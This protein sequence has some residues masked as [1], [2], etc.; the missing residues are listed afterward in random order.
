MRWPFTHKP[1]PKPAPTT[2][3]F[4]FLYDTA[5]PAGQHE[6]F[7]RNPDAT[8]SRQLTNDPTTDSWWPRI[9]PDKQTI[10]YCSTPKGVRDTDFTKV[11][12]RTVHIDGTDDRQVLGTA[13]ETNPDW[14]SYGHPDWKPDGTT[15]VMF[16]ITQ[17]ASSLL[18]EYDTTSWKPSRCAR[19]ENAGSFC[20][21]PSYSPDGLKIVFV[22]NVAGVQKLSTVGTAGPVNSGYT[23][24]NN[25]PASW[26][27]NDPYYSPDSLRIGALLQTAAADTEHSGGQ[28][29]I[30]GMSA[31]GKNLITIIDDGNINSKPDWIDNQ[32]ILFHRLVYS[33]G[34]GGFGVWTI[35]SDGTGLT[36][37]GVTGEYPNK[38]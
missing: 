2:S 13:V 23:E 38:I 6:I 35:R 20:A 14:K 3:N 17:T 1:A 19:L 34:S 12:I 30:I 11:S 21:D 24:L 7:V 22:E 18:I 36:A 16:L 4:G 28:W 5:V 33:T 25:A 26:S 8:T 37:L 29:S 9:S 32:T 15:I 27:W 31:D 10:L